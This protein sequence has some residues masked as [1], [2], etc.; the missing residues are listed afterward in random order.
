MQTA[1]SA[2]NT[3]NQLLTNNLS[4]QNVLTKSPMHK[5]DDK[6]SIGILTP[7]KTQALLNREIADKLQQRFKDEGI[8]LKGLNADDFTPEK[9]SDRIL[10][11]VSGHILGESDNEKQNELMA[12]ARE[13]IEQGF[14]EARDILESLDVLNG[15]VK[16]DIDSTYDLI[17]KGLDNLE[18]KINGTALEDADDDNALKDSSNVQQASMQ[19]SFS[20]NENTRIEITTTD[21]DKI[22]IDLFKEQ[23]AQSVQ[24]YSQNEDGSTYSQSRT[25]SASTGITY[26]VQGELDN[27]EQKAIDDLLK[28][29]AK[30]SDQFFKGNIQQAFKKAMDMDFDSRELVLFSLNLSYQETRQTAISTYNNY[31]AQS[32]PD[33]QQ[34]A[35]ES[36]GLKDMSDFIKQIDQLLQN[37]FANNM[38]DTAQGIGDLLKSMNQML[39]ANEMHQLEK[40]S[41]QLLDSLIHQL[42][43]LH[44]ETS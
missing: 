10:S 44:S 41:T 34:Q 6:V 38:A 16:S 21:G 15:K 39:H 42:Q 11:F 4:K 20:R 18:Q 26:Q 3:Q 31:Q 23:S 27:D 5:A 43:Q 2:I 28:D 29:V 12:Q 25:L 22:L 36:A 32:Q 8:E 24:H 13:G 7:E 1:L 30:V 33:A 35:V 37:P 9:V 14:A 17:Q 19:S 40:D